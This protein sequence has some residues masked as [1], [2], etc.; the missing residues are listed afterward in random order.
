MKTSFT[1]RILEAQLQLGLTNGSTQS[2]I[3]S[4]KAKSQNFKKPTVH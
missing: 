3:D 2:L 4:I 1:K